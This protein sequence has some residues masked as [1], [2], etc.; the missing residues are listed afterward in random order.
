ML[1]A[2]LIPTR[3]ADLIMVVLAWVYVALRLAHA[4]IHV[5]DNYVPRR[6]AVFAAA[7]FRGRPG[8]ECFSSPELAGPP[9]KRTLDATISTDARGL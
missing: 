8:V 1:V 3:H 7:P 9:R 6:G 5:T 4:Y 2:Y